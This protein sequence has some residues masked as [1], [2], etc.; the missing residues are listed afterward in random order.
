MLT[1]KLEDMSTIKDMLGL[2]LKYLVWR[3]L[4]SLSTLQ[5]MLF[6]L[7]LLIMVNFR[8]EIRFLGKIFKNGSK[9]KAILDFGLSSRF[10]IKRFVKISLRV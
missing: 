3:L 4:I 8:K 6:N 9:L 5:M 7:A 1:L 2:L 10:N